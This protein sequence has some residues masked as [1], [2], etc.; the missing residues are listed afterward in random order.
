MELDLAATLAAAR[1]LLAADTP[2]GEGEAE[3]ACRLLD[4]LLRTPGVLRADADLQRGRIGLHPLSGDP[5]RILVT[6]SPPGR[7]DLHLS[8]LP[9]RTDE[10]LGHSTDADELA[11]AACR[12]VEELD[13]LTRA[14]TDLGAG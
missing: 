2:P 4:A 9:I 3:R 8:G 7:P 1:P 5:E 12:I 13:R 10:L 11:W 6:L 14:I